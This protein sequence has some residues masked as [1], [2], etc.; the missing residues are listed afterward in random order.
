[1]LRFLS[2]Y[3]VTLLYRLYFVSNNSKQPLF[4]TVKQLVIHS[5]K[6]I[7]SVTM[8]YPTLV[9]RDKVLKLQLIHFL[10]F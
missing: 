7:L 6:I 4:L 8:M 9:S 1:M 5:K 10:F 3:S 2:F